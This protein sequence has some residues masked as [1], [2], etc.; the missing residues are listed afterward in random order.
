MSNK[1]EFARI[2]PSWIQEKAVDLVISAV[3]EDIETILC[4]G[5]A[6]AANKA[7][8]LAA[9]RGQVMNIA[10]TALFSDAKNEIATEQSSPDSNVPQRSGGNDISEQQEVPY[11]RTHIVITPD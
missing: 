9:F 8:R 10:M 7:Y 6:D 2:V 3:Q 11:F 5:D 4:E 1:T